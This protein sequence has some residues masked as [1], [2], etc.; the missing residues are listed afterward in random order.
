MIP[1]TAGRFQAHAEVLKL[2][3]LLDKPAEELAFLEEV[4]PAHLSALREQ[5]TNLLFDANLGVLQRMA[6]A[7]RLLP[8]PV[9]A[10]IAER[11]FGPLLCARMAGL[12]ETS[13]GV[14]VAKRL[15]PAFLADVAALLDPRR[16]SDI[17]TSIPADLV[18]VVARE[19][20]RREDWIAIGQF[21]GNLPDET[22]RAALAEID[23]GA[24]LRVAFVLDDKDEVD[25]VVNLLGRQRLPGLARQAGQQDAWA[26]AFD[27]L[28]HLGAANANLLA[29]AISELEPE[30]RAQAAER[31]REYGLYDQFPIL[32]KAL[33]T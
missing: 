12:V 16:A 11:V 9:L 13:R 6:G 14:D 8:A 27:L 18:R 10:R 32:R 33:G 29:T 22:V 15:S 7:S 28:S 31:A 21:A 2:A 20:A 1:A 4:D 5:V 19:L 17:I 24:L 25:N 23:D 26:A 30:L 3:R